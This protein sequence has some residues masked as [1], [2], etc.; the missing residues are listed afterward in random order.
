[1]QQ[2]NIE[3]FDHSEFQVAVESAME[4]LPSRTWKE[5]DIHTF[6]TETM[7]IG[8]TLDVRGEVIPLEWATGFVF[9]AIQE[10][11]VN[12]LTEAYGEQIREYLNRH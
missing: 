4:A 9:G 7:K 2:V 11:V 10:I 5:Q 8:K 1:M 3:T 12:R 6:I